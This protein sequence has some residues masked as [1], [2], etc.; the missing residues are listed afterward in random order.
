MYRVHFCLYCTAAL[1][2][3]GG[4]VAQSTDWLTLPGQYT[5]DPQTGERV[6]QYAQHMPSYAPAQSISSSSGFRHTRSSLQVGRSA[7]HYHRVEKW[8]EPVRPYGE[9]RFPYRPYAVP[10]PEWGPIYPSSNSFF[11]FSRGNF[12][13]PRGG[14][15]ADV[16]AARGRGFSPFPSNYPDPYP[17]LPGTGYDVPPYFDGGYPSLPVRPRL[18][19][20][21]FYF[22]PNQQP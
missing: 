14:D 3:T 19:D 8:G 9:W 5:H 11:G 4:S 1:L 6:H 12:G 21:D 15:P 20:E 10:Y 2:F 16:D 17:S 18:P 13:A 22:E 7:D